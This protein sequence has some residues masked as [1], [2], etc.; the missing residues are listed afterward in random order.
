MKKLSIDESTRFNNA[1]YSLGI[2][3]EALLGCDSSDIFEY[4]LVK[5]IDRTIKLY[6]IEVEL[7][8]GET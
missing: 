7:K 5:Y 2:W 3:E 1:K 8:G 4:Y 6:N